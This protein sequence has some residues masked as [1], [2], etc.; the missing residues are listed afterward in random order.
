VLIVSV[1]VGLFFV[2]FGALA[3]TPHVVETWIGTAPRAIAGQPWLSVELVKVSAALAAFSGLYYAIAVLTEAGYRE[4]FLDDVETSLR[5]T[6]E[7]RARYLA[8][9]AEQRAP[10]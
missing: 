6:F 3:I 1:L 10:A 5:E 4:E 9:R 8:L 2:A 7:D